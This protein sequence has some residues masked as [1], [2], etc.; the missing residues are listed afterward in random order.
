VRVRRGPATVTGDVPGSQTL[1]AVADPR[2]RG[3]GPSRRNDAGR[4]CPYPPRRKLRRRPSP[5]GRPAAVHRRHGASRRAFL[6]GGV[7]DGEPRPCRARRVARA[8]RRC[9]RRGAAAAGRAARV[10]RGRGRAGG[11]GQAGRAARR[12]GRAGRRAD[13][14]VHGARR[15]RL[16]GARLPRRGRAREPPRAAPL[17]FRH[18]AA[19]GRGLR[20]ARPRARLRRARRPSARSVPAD[21]GG[22]LLPGPRT[23]GQHRVR[24]HAVRRDR[25]PRGERA[26]GVL[27]VAPRRRPCPDGAA[28][29]RRRARRDR[30]RRRRDRRGGGECRRGRGRLGRRRARRP[31]RP[32]AAGPVPDD[33]AGHVGG[34]RRRALADGRGDA[35]GDSGVRRAARDR[36]V[37]VQGDG[38]GRRHPDL[39]G[40]PRAGGPARRDRGAARAAAGHAGRGAQARGGAVELPDQALAGRQRRRARHAGVRGGAAAGA[41]RGRV[42]RRRLPRRLR[43]ADPLADRGGRA[44]RRVADGG[45]ARRGARA[46]PARGLP[47]LVRRAPRGA[48]RGHARA[49]GGAAG[50]ALRRPGRDRA[51]V[52]DLRQ[53]RPHDPTAARVRR[54]PGGDLP[55]PGPAAVAPLPRR[56]PLAR[57]GVRRRRRDPPGQAR[58]AGVAARQGPRARGRGRP[59]RGARR[60]AAGVPV[61]RQR[62]G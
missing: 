54:E 52:A 49:L 1:A 18:R 51:G 15:G 27:R 13:G 36:A 53:R 46:R 45:A 40:R 3:R 41:A 31:G 26:T 10:A 16:G 9:G 23:V 21:R 48:D 5:A 50:L 12:R 7:P 32:R 17:P 38:G 29:A 58:H 56:L 34:L 42:H 37:L 43:R 20:S 57:R 60:A 47:A 55:R 8:P 39:R 61:H 6:R 11:V 22:G 59:R 2:V 4:A 28:R 35:G 44:R 62:P 33:V 25:G 14:G 24:R 30:A 19:H